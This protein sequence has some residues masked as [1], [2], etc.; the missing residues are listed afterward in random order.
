MN[1]LFYYEEL[2]RAA[3]ER[4]NKLVDLSINAKG[5][6]LQRISNQTPS[7]VITTEDIDLVAQRMMTSL[8]AVLCPQA[9]ADYAGISKL[10]ELDMH[11][12]R[13]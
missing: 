11:D 5:A 7:L 2:Y 6:L 12:N 3:V 10:M 1:M 4:M 9:A 13:E 8:G